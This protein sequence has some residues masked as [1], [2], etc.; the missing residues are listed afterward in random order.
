MKRILAA[1]VCLAML[2]SGAL[3]EVNRYDEVF[4]P[5]GDEGNLT[6]RFLWLGPQV[7]DDKPGDSMILTSPDGKI[8]VLDAGHPDAAQYVTDALDK[9][10]VTKIDYLVA[11]HPHIDHIGGFP[12]LMDKYEIG[13][14]YTS[15]LEYPT[16]SYNAYMDKAR[17]KNIQHII[18]K[19]GDTLNFGEQVTVEVLNPPSEIVYPDNYPTGSTQFVNN[20]SLALKFTYGTSTILLCGDLYTGGEKDVVSRWGDKL[21]CDVTKANHHGA[22]TSSSSKWR[23]AV[24][25]EITIV[26]S[27]A[28]ESLS[29]LKKYIRNDKLMYHILWDGCIRLSTPGDGTYQV[30]TEKERGKTILD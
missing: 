10:G 8:M 1:L 24:T 22:D 6:V 3:A 26:T 17:E 30:L 16:A 19:E 29:N 12:A 7:A 27:D 9:L 23:N 21:D 2:I 28:I 11:S 25:A 20:H 14:L 15:P 18:L 5:A 4:D 13:A